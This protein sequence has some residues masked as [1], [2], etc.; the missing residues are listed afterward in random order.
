[1][2]RDGTLPTVPWDVLGGTQ[3]EADKIRAQMRQAAGV[4]TNTNHATNGQR[5][6]LVGDLA[7]PTPSR[8]EPI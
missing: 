2:S 1:M 7:A 8:S 4:D 3:A 6:R 5:I